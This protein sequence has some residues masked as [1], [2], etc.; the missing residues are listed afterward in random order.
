MKIIKIFLPNDLL[1]AKTYTHLYRILENEA[2]KEVMKFFVIKHSINLCKQNEK[3]KYIGII[4][5]EDDLHPGLE[6]TEQY[7]VFTFN[8]KS[9]SITIRKLATPWMHKNNEEEPRNIQLILYDAIG[10]ENLSKNKISSDEITSNHE[11]IQLARLIKMR[12]SFPE[13]YLANRVLEIKAFFYRQFFTL[14]SILSF[15]LQPFRFIFKRTAVY[16]HS[17]DWVKCVQTYNFEKYNLHQ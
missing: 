6:K 16:R 3:L 4:K 8:D 10:F 7:V 11:L 14:L 5:H 1:T 12:N 9:D 15:I 13:S 2:E 17:L